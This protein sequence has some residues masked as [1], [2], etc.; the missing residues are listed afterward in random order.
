MTHDSSMETALAT[1]NSFGW[2]A[3]S[4]L[5]VKSPA[6]RQEL[7]LAVIVMVRKEEEAK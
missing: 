5:E 7:I 6:P 3:F 4:Q 1:G 2:L